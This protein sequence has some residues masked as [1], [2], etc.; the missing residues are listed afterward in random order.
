MIPFTAFLLVV[1]ILLVCLIILQRVTIAQMEED[2]DIADQLEAI[3]D[4]RIHN[5]RNALELP[6]EG[7]RL[8]EIPIQGT[9]TD[10]GEPHIEII[11]LKIPAD[12]QLSAGWRWAEED[13]S[14]PIGD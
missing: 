5:L 12:T 10:T 14:E 13:S 11:Y 4:H 2:L 8:C 6:T 9:Y 3:K 1:I 7:W